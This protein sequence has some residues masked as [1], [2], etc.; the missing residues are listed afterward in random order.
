MLLQKI[1]ESSI[2][3]G[4]DVL[5]E[6]CG[7]GYRVTVMHSQPFG[8]RRRAEYRILPAGTGPAYPVG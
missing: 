7:P 4:R 2:E 5:Q 6:K 8:N 1:P 3:E